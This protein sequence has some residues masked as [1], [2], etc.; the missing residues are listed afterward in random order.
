MMLQKLLNLHGKRPK[1][2]SE[3][4]ENFKSL[5]HLNQ[6]LTLYMKTRLSHVLIKKNGLLTFHNTNLCLILS[7]LCS[8]AKTLTY[9][10]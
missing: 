5:L 4:C 9:S 2:H 6:Q 3:F 10:L 1:K 7:F 8:T